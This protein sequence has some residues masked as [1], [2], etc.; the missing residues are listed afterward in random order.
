MG[1]GDRVISKENKIP[2]LQSFPQVG[3]NDTLSYE[4]LNEMILDYLFLG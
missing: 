3:G 1:A 2:V 4:Q